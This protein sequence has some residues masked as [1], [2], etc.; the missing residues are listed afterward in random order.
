[1]TLPHE[2]I[3]SICSALAG[4]GWILLIFAPKWKFTQWFVLSGAISLVIGGVYLI[5]LL[6]TIGGEGGGAGNFFTFAGVKQ[7]FQDDNVVLAGWIHYLAF[8][9]FIGAWEVKDAKEWGI[10][11]WWMAPCLI[12]T[13]MYGPVGLL[14][15]FAVRAI[16]KK[17]TSR[18]KN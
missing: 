5:V 17:R 8:D 6:T 1:M 3:F 14:T 2:L 7:L 9:L 13:C 18:I 16:L 10:S 15:Y 11:P 12:L 4:I